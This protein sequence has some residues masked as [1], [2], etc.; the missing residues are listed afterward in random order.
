MIKVTVHPQPIVSVGVSADASM[1]VNVGSTT[2]MDP[3]ELEQYTGPYEV[4]PKVNSQTLSTA[5]KMLRDDITVREVPYYEVSNQFG[6]N[7][8]YIAKEL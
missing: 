3:S 8:V 1:K 5:R 7:T 4:V 2:M 6:G